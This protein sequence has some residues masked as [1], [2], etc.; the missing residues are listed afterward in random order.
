M[1]KNI[2]LLT[3]IF[4]LS[5]TAFADTPN[6]KKIFKDTDACFILFDLTTNKNVITYNSNRCNERVFACSTFKIPIAIMAFDQK[7]LQDENTVIKWDQITRETVPS[8]N[9]DQTPKSW[10]QNSTVWVSQWIMPQIGM[11]KI[12]KYLRLFS[13]GNQDMSGGITKAWLGYSLKISAYEQMNF[14]KNLWK[15]TLPISSHAMALLKKCLPKEIT[16]SGNIFYG[17][18]GAGYIDGGEDPNGRMLGWFVG[19]VIHDNYQY[20]FVTNF[21]DLKSNSTESTAT[22][23]GER[24]KRFTKEILQEM[25]L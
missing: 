17:K 8:W 20:V 14:L 22:N 16:S 6:F 5:T 23:P 9:Q 10:L 2:Y 25:H 7:I 4:M 18:T 1:K 19:Y 13:Y 21:T 3:I 12:K 15:G 11:I 24:A